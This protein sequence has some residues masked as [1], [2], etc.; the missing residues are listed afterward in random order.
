V[1]KGHENRLREAGIKYKYTMVFIIQND[2]DERG[3]ATEVDLHANIHGESLSID[4]CCCLR[5]NCRRADLRFQESPLRVEGKVF[6]T[7]AAGDEAFPVSLSASGR[8]LAF[9]SPDL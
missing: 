3:D 9:F 7:W 2:E 6:M 1:A 5:Y 8:S 4:S